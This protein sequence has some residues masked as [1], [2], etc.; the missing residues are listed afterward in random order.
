MEITQQVTISGPGIAGFIGGQL[1]DNAGITF[2]RL[3]QLSAAALFGWLF[4]C[5]FPYICFCKRYEKILFQQ[6]ENQLRAFE[7]T[8]DEAKLK[9]DGQTDEQKM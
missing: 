5:A 3:F 9:S 1:V 8:E 2:P 7:M 4:L 6:K